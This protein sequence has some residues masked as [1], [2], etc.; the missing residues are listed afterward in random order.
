[1]NL[2]KAADRSNFDFFSIKKIFSHKSGRWDLE[3][4]AGILVKLPRKNI[5]D[6]LEFLVLFLDQNKKKKI[7]KIDLRQKD[8]IILNG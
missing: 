1:M 4:E 8:Q 7:N 6:S 3:L 5:I 2:K